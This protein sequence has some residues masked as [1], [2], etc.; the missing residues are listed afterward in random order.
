MEAY[1]PTSSATWMRAT[2]W[3]RIGHCACEPRR[4]PASHRLPHHCASKDGN[5][6]RQLLHCDSVYRT[7]PHCIRTYCWKIASGGALGRPERRMRL[8]TRASS[9]WGKR[10][11]SPLPLSSWRVP[12]RRWIDRHRLFPPPA[13]GAADVSEAKKKCLY[14]SLLYAKESSCNQNF[15]TSSTPP[16][17]RPLPT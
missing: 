4:C 15:S 1:C 14:I 13:L 12:W 16:A 5:G 11:T 9:T 8:C 7:L 2:T 3:T 10:A 6:E 17:L